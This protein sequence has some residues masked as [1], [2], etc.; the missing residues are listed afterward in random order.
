MELILFGIGFIALLATIVVRSNKRD[1]RFA[2]SRL[3]TKGL[4]VF[5]IGW[6]M[7]VVGASI[8]THS[9]A[10]ILRYAGYLAAIIG[11]CMAVA[12]EVRHVKLMFGPIDAKRMVDPG[13][14]IPYTDCP[15]CHEIEVRVYGRKAKCPKCGGVI[16]PDKKD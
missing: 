13:Y 9:A 4:L 15:H 14:D 7:L 5:G 2:G 1:P 16:R 12:G 3:M 10:T 8:G 11:F 6:L